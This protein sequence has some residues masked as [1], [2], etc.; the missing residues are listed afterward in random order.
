VLLVA[1]NKAGNWTHWYKQAIP[2]AENLYEQWLVF[3]NQR[4][5]EKE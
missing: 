1:G 4:R 3:E 2:I 5:E